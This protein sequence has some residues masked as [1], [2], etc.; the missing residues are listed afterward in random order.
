MAS[1][2]SNSTHIFYGSAALV[3]IAAEDAHLGCI[4]EIIDVPTIVFDDRQ[5]SLIW[6]AEHLPIDELVAPPSCPLALVAASQAGY[7][8][9]SV[10]NKWLATASLNTEVLRMSN[11]V[12]AEQTALAVLKRLMEQSINANRRFAN[13]LV[14]LREQ[15]AE[16]RRQCQESETLISDLR[17]ALAVKGSSLVAS[18]DPSD[19]KW[20]PETDGSSISF[21]IPFR[22]RGL[23]QMDLHFRAGGAGSGSIG[24]R[25]SRAEESAIIGSWVISHDEADGWVALY[26]SRALE[27]QSHLLTLQVDWCTEE[28]VAP[29]LSFSNRYVQ[30]HGVGAIDGVMNRE[31]LPAIRLYTALPGEDLPIRY[32]GAR[33]AVSS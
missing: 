21:R 12:S 17:E 20:I 30:P 2:P 24:I 9:L 7:D 16:L 6:A 32:S 14:D 11:G 27:S 22:A 28:G 3:I 18:C 26:L 23:S 31:C 19:R 8:G 1:Y 25:L 10:L 33:I 5:R 15:L 29:Q 4:S 13:V